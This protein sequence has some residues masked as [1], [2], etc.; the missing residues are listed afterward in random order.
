MGLVVV[1]S[2]NHFPHYYQD[3]SDQNKFGTLSQLCKF[4]QNQSPINIKTNSTR[5]QLDKFPLI[6]EQFDTIPQKI[7]LRNNGNSVT[8]KLIYADGNTSSITGGPL[9][10]DTYLLEHF[11]LHWGTTR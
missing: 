11:H 2:S 3:Q 7:F 9:E 5:E 4:G 1:S 6:I 10:S 8:F